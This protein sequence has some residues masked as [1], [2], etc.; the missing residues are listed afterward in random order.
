[1]KHRDHKKKKRKTT[2]RNP[3]PP[4]MTLGGLE[5]EMSHAHVTPAKHRAFMNAMKEA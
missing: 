5:I 1:M 2:P 3:S 4:T